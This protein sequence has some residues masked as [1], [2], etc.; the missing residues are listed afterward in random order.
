M[1]LLS[2]SQFP[3]IFLSYGALKSYLNATLSLVILNKV[4]P[5][6]YYKSFLSAR[7]YSSILIYLHKYADSHV[8]GGNICY[9]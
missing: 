7:P 8:G 9:Y 1:E 6:I 5:K 4:S 3:R 2:Q